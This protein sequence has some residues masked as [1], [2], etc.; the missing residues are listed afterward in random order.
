MDGRWI[1]AGA[2]I[3]CG[4]LAGAVVGLILR[5]LLDREDRRPALRETAAPLSL[6]AFWVLTAT[7]IVLAIAVSSPETLKPIPRDILDWLPN[8]A[9]AGLLIIGGYALGVTLAATVG[10]AFSRT[11]GVRQR[12]LERAVRTAVFVGAIIFALS[13]LG[14]DTTVLNILIGGIA[15]GGAAGLAGIA[16]IGARSVAGHVAAG[17]SLQAALTL[18]AEI[19]VG[20]LTGV[21][22]ETQ[23]AHVVLETETGPVMVPYGTIID[24]PIH[25]LSAAGPVRPEQV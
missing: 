7:G 12:T 22:V 9:L 13:Q 10:R 2:A 18:G 19:R 3:V 11:S 25:L 24:D 5:R 1:W 20:E 21:V 8:V 23:I 6:F 14:V 4:V 15:F 17:R 16:I